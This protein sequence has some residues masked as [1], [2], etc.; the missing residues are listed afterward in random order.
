MF[1]IKVTG[2]ASHRSGLT[3]LNNLDFW[4]EKKAS[5]YGLYEAYE[6]SNE[7]N[8]WGKAFT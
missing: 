1:N 4:K 2:V 3:L 5:K 6:E 7:F 8:L